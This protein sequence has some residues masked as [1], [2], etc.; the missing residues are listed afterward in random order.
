M[1]RCVRWV[2]VGRGFTHADLP[3][4][5][6][7]RLTNRSSGR[8]LRPGEYRLVATPRAGGMTG[9][10]LRVKFRIIAAPRHQ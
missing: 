4:P 7:F 3:G 5:N 9:N 10:T 1:T 2:P 8:N 6:R